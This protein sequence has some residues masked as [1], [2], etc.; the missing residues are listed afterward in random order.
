MPLFSILLLAQAVTTPVTPSAPPAMMMP[1]KESEPVCIRAGDLPPEFAG[2]SMPPTK[3]LRLGA[4]A[5]IDA[6]DPKTVKWVIPAPANKP[7]NGAVVAFTIAKAGTYRIGLSN[8]AWIDVVAKG[9]ALES[10]AHGH[11]PAC[12]ELRKI[13]DFKLTPG[14]YVLQFAGMPAPTT[15]VM[16]A[17]K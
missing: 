6:Q 8:G 13:V 15:K 16:I 17:A 5:I 14:N 1:R 12:T 2:W 9:K 7:G 4:P 3:L 11:G 10:V